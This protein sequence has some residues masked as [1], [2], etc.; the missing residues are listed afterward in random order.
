MPAGAEADPLAGI[1]EIGPTLEIV[2]F[3]AGRIDQHFLWRRL[4]R[5]G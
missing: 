3:E 2:A 1:I 5:Q 4:A